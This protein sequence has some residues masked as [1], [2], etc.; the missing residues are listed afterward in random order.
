[1]RVAKRVAGLAWLFVVGVLLVS[2]GTGSA[3]GQAL[4]PA[5]T[6]PVIEGYGPVYPVESPSFVTPLDADYRL[7][8]DVKTAPDDTE[9]VNP[10]IETLARFLNMHARAGVAPERMQLALVLHGRAGKDALDHEGF[11][12]RHGHD[13][14]NLELIEK[15]DAAGVEII[16][17]GQTAMHRGLPADR[18]AA[19]VKLALSAM[20][21][22][23]VL[24]SRGYALIA[25]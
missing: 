22:L 5:R 17:C 25:F 19:P 11:R 18:L 8:F 15:L 14:P 13:N 10:A 23:S 1:V 2:L 21:A 24:Q 9:A 3:A 16:L 12:A 6:G 7:V 4:A 20:T